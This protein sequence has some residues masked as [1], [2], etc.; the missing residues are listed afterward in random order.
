MTDDTFL[1][2]ARSLL[3]VFQRRVI[4]ANVRI[5]LLPG[6]ADMHPDHRNRPRTGRAGDLPPG[7]LFRTIARFIGLLPLDQ[8]CQFRL[9]ARLLPSQ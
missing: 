8:F 4:S 7:V 1:F 3:N 5:E 9:A 2:W 6:G